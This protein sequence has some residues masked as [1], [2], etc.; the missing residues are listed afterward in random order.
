[1]KL[2]EESFSFDRDLDQVRMF[3]LK[4]YHRTGALHYLIP[5][6]V[7]N[8]KY[9]P[10]GPKYSPSDDETIKIWR[11]SDKEDSEIIAVSHRG[12]A[13]NYHIE[14]HPDHKHMEKELYREVENLEKRIVG[15]RKSRMYTYTV[16]SDSQRPQVL[17]ELG[18]EDRGLHEY[19][20]EFPQDATIPDNPL[21]EGYSIRS[22]RGEEDYSDFIELFA[23]VNDH[24][25][26]YLTIE[27]MKFMAHA[28][29]YNDNLSLIVADDTGQFVGFC[30]FRLDPLT[31][32]AE[33]EAVGTYPNFANIGLEEA[34]IS[35]GLR[36]VVKQ[37]PDLIC[38][39]EVDK[40]ESLNQ[41][42]ESAGF[43][44]SVTMNQWWKMVESMK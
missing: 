34:L 37:H 33:L 1:M 17:T 5:T 40:S 9:G 10:C 38:C 2:V 7:E 21:P 16:G 27:R 39:V 24:C 32:I 28:E 36:H 19:N 15:E 42:V 26:E 8:Q 4:I 31:K 11:L 29:F 25:R 23:T 13:G 35:E 20:Y 6:K 22:L 44:Q 3:L 14:I 18:Y 41:M 43:I 30:M 12:S